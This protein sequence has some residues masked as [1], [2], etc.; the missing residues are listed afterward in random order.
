MVH[1]IS[2]LPNFALLGKGGRAEKEEKQICNT[3][4]RLK[5]LG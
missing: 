3:L 4:V 5:M 2:P 1:A